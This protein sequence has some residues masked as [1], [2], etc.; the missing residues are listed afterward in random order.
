MCVWHAL[1][2]VRY[3]LRLAVAEMSRTALW[4]KQGGGSPL[5]EPGRE[6]SCSCVHIFSLSLTHVA[7]TFVSLKPHMQFTDIHAYATWT[8]PAMIWKPAACVRDLI[9]MHMHM[10]TLTVHSHTESVLLKA[11][12]SCRG[13]KPEALIQPSAWALLASCDFNRGTFQAI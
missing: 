11:C 7:H 5:Q 2:H 6:K 4:L 3:W 12:T 8:R 13:R 10:I 9:H 1:V